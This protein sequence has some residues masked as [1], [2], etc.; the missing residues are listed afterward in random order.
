MALMSE[1]LDLRS[2]KNSDLEVLV[3]TSVAVTS[4]RAL[5][6]AKA[7]RTGLKNRILG[8]DIVLCGADSILCG[9]RQRCCSTTMFDTTMFDTGVRAGNLSLDE[10]QA[11]LLAAT[12]R[13]CGR[14][15][16]GE[17]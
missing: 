9:S 6:A 2:L 13:R 10:D 15:C 12:I 17:H 4:L 11:K 3:T 5:Y 1:Y 7:W 14:G 8:F 16:L